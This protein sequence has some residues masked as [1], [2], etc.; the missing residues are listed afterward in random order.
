MLQKAL[1]SIGNVGGNGDTEVGAS[2]IVGTSIASAK[3]TGAASQV[4]AA[5]PNLNA[6]QVK[7][8]LK[9]TAVDL[10]TS[11][12]DTETGAGLLNLGLAVQAAMITQGKTY[13]FDDVEMSSG[14]GLRNGSGTPE[15][16]PAFLTKLWNGVKKAVNK[17]V[18]FVKKVVAVVQKVVAVVQK[19]VS[20]VKKAIPIITKMGGFLSKIASKFVCLPILGKIGIVLGGIALVGAAIG[21][22]ILWFKNRKKQQQQTQQQT[23]VETVVVQQDPQDILD[24]EAAWKLLTPAQQNDIGPALKNGIDPKYQ[25]LFDGTDPDGII[26]LLDTVNGLSTEQQNQLGGYLLNGAPSAWTS[27][28]DGTDPANPFIPPAVK[29]AWNS[30]TSAQ[31]NVLKPAMLNGITSPYGRPLFDGDPD[32]IGKVLGVLGSPMLNNTQ[33]SLMTSFLFN[34]GGIPT[35]YENRFI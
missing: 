20:F 31:Q 16:R 17:V 19:V 23:V 22:A 1:A 25:S 21:G 4:W 27:F 15:E 6:A 14:L 3:V 8:I 33:R 9:A 2:A 29:N 34:P 11:G 30:L 10:Q 13:A 35:Q 18:T 7:E 12:W 26:P 32:G 28:F 5:N 24:L